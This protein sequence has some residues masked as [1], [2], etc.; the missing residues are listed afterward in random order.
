[1]KNITVIN[2]SQTK[3]NKK[4]LEIILSD[5]ELILKGIIYNIKPIYVSSRDS[6]D[7][8]FLNSVEIPQF[9]SVDEKF[10]NQLL[11]NRFGTEKSLEELEGETEF[12]YH[13]EFSIEEQCFYINEESIEFTVKVKEGEPQ[14]FTDKNDEDF[15]A[16]MEN[17][18]P[19]YD[20]TN[21]IQIKINI[22][23]A[24]FLYYCLLDE[25]NQELEG[26]KVACAFVWETDFWK[27]YQKRK[28]M[29][30][31]KVRKC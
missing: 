7:N 26:E 17:I 28:I 12:T 10:E 6:D 1:M 8:F 31:N 20:K 27:T 29:L 30:D 5:K 24:P 9:T 25:F 18:T 19:E 15:I 4:I 22:P 23:F 13:L 21:N 16:S 3:T 14:L 2:K 11:M